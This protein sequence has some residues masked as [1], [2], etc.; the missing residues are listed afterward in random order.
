M[1]NTSYVYTKKNKTN[2]KVII[3][4]DQFYRSLF[5]NNPDIVYFLDPLGIIA[6]TNEVFSEM[7]G[8]TKDEI[9][10]RSIESFL[11]LSEISLYNESLKLVLSNMT[12][13]IDTVFLHKNG[14]SIHINLTLIPAKNNGEVIGVFGI[15]KD[16]SERKKVEELHRYFAYHDSL[17]NLP[18]RRFFQEKVEQQLTRH[19]TLKQKFA[20]MYLDIDRFKNINHTFGTYIGDEMLK[21]ISN[22]LEKYREGEN[23]LARVNG[24]QYGALILNIKDTENIIYLA[25]QIIDLIEK[26]F[27]IEDYKIYITV[28]I[29]ISIYP[30]DGEDA[31][32]IMNHAQSA[33]YKAKENGKNTYQ[34]YSSTMNIQ[35]FKSYSLEADLRKAVELN[36]LELFYQP[37]VSTQTLQIVGAEALIR[38]NHPEWGLLSPIEFIPL[39]EELGLSVKLGKWVKRTAALQNKAWQLDG[40]PAIPISINLSAKRFLQTD[41]IQSTADILKESNLDPQFLEIEITETS[42]LENEKVVF[43][44]LDQ[45]KHMGIKISLDDFGTGYSS[46]SYLKRF[47]GRIDT[48]KIDR[49]FINDLSTE[50]TENDNF[51]T[52]SIIQLAQ[53]LKM[54]VVAEGVETKE[55]LDILKKYKCDTI[56]GY[57]FSKPI[58]VNEFASLLRMKQFEI[59]TEFK[60]DTNFV[61][62]QHKCYRVHLDV[63]LLALMTPIK[64]H[65]RKV[66]LGKTDVLIENIGLAGL[67]FLSD[68]KL[69][70]H[71]DTLLQFESKILGNWIKIQGTIIRMHE[72]QEGIYQY[73]L[74][75]SIDE[76]EQKFLSQLLNKFSNMLKKNQIITDCSFVQMD[77]YQF[78]KKKN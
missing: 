7:L 12:Q 22:R 73:G 2:G 26:P 52:K 44:I 32:T 65:G 23:V 16:I 17:T 39:A 1:T 20:V 36:Q 21:Q 19:H 38:W 64:I 69:P 28:S 4:T 30:N 67:G 77:R 6:K 40:L 46:L 61:L 34:I 58:P 13:N 68:I 66:E 48:L 33:L 59:P 74:S 70:I 15:A 25:K 11:P 55:Q 9:V 41:L 56:Q 37:K 71:Q 45:I 75:F 27:L 10:L 57:L 18:N 62:N 60:T 5:E 8:Y 47:K 24:D 3:D 35:T 54:D 49:S 29:G 63:P 76:D 72:A 50:N 43:S 78:F 31:D 42:L 14:N 53:H 51:I